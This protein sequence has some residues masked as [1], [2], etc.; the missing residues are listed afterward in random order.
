MAKKKKKI[1]VVDDEAPIREVV[2]DMLREAGYAVA[3]AENGEQALAIL[4]K[5]T[6]DL[7]CLDMSMPRMGGITF[8]K[9][10]SSPVDGKVRIPIIVITGRADLEPVFKDLDVVA[11]MTKPFETETL[12]AKVHEVF[13]QEHIKTPSDIFPDQK[14]EDNTFTDDEHSAS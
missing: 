3:T 5:V 7:I 13:S 12:I 1:L 9:R 8:F 10:I 6:P 2:A 4:E 11:F 14:D